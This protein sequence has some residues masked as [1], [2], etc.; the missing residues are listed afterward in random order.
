MVKKIKKNVL[1]CVAH[2]DDETIGCGGTI[3]RHVFE[4]DKVYCVAMT[5]GVSSRDNH[6]N[7]D[8]KFR[9]K[10]KKNAEK[11]LGFKWLQLNK[12][13]P[14]NQMDTVKLLTIVKE[15]EQIKKKIKPSIVYTH[16]P[17]DL[18]I[19]HRITAEAT[20]T[21]FRPHTKNLEKILAFEIPSSTDYRYYKKKIFNPNYFVD[22]KKFW[23]IKK[24]ALVAYKQELKKYP[25]SRSLKSIEILSKFRGSQNSLECAEGFVILKQIIR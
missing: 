15:I 21:A 10:S 7:K 4:G 23:K 9:E 12:D 20:L 5:N 8:I 13:F 17:D 3:A 25:N 19:D 1:I 14:D 6:E 22:I 11:I 2:P 24:K 16:F 18:N